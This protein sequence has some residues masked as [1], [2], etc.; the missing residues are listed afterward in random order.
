M[1][2]LKRTPYRVCVS[3]LICVV[4]FAWSVNAP[5]IPLPLRQC[6][7]FFHL[8]ESYCCTPPGGIVEKLGRKNHTVIQICADGTGN[9]PSLHPAVWVWLG[10]VLK[11]NVCI[12][13]ELELCFQVVWCLWGL[14]LPGMDDLF[15]WSAFTCAYCNTL[16]TG[17]KIVMTTACADTYTGSQPRQIVFIILAPFCR[18]K[19]IKRLQT[20]MS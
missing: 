19:L 5:Q 7:A 8:I 9:S 16:L 6:R 20:E 13:D 4:V 10:A 12:L 11:V 2:R 18:V 17:V 1:K 3:K 14:T 15:F